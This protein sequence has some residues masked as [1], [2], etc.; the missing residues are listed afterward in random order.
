MDAMVWA[1]TKLLQMQ[2]RP[3]IITET[4]WRDGIV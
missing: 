2:K 1:M 3:L 4:D